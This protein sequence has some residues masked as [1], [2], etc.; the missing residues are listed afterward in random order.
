[1]TARTNDYNAMIIAE[2]RANEGRVGGRAEL[3][4]KLVAEVPRLD[5]FQ[6]RVRRQIPVLMLSRESCA[7]TRGATTHA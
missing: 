2:Y 5:H 1:M 6:T 7:D 3:W 4:P